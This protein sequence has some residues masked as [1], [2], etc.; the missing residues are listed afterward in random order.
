MALLG[1]LQVIGTEAQGDSPLLHE[2]SEK[3]KSSQVTSGVEAISLTTPVSSSI[4]VSEVAPLTS[5]EAPLTQQFTENVVVPTA[6]PEQTSATEQGAA[7]DQASGASQ[8]AATEPTATPTAEPDSGAVDEPCIRSSNGAPYCTYVVKS[9]DTLSAIAAGLGLENT[10]AFSAAELLALSNGLND[11]QNWLILPGQELRVPVETGVIHT[12]KASETISVLADLYG[13]SMADIIR[14]NNLTDA[15]SV[16]VGE[17]LV[18]PSPNF[19]PIS[20]PNT[21]VAADSS[22]PEAEATTAEGTPDG[23]DADATAT[24]EAEVSAVQATAPLSTNANPSVAEIRDQF[25]AGYIAAGGPPQYMEHLLDVVI[26]C[27]SG[28]NLRAYN[29]NGPFYG[30]VQFLPL[31]WANSGGGDWFSAWQQGFNTATLLLVA[32]PTSQWP[33]CWR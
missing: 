2:L 28:Y 8:D 33:N 26:P 12:V 5:R 16:V 4:E 14:A 24:P 10:P 27:E 13:V 22:S 18:I 25:A 19:W 15:N 9:G 20:G 31:T 30:L 21:A 29:P 23:S 17:T 3:V 7:A 11:A 1:G 6:A 32:S